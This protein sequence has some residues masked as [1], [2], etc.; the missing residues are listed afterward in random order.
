MNSG[1]E[2]FNFGEISLAA[3]I[4]VAEYSPLKDRHI[5]QILRSSR[6]TLRDVN[7]GEEISSRSKD[8]S[9]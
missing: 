1:N 7:E 5:E 6:M 3:I 8:S 9:I 4:K 2:S